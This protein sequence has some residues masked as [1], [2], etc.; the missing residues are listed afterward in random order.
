MDQRARLIAVL[1]D[2]ER[3]VALAGILSRWMVF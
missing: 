3:F 1:D 2:Q